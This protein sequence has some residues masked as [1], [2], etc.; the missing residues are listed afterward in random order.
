MRKVYQELL[1]FALEFADAAA[2]QIMPYYL[3]PNSSWA[4]RPAYPPGEAGSA[5]V[6][7]LNLVPLQ[8]YQKV[9]PLLSV[10]NQK[11]DL[12]YVFGSHETIFL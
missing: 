12:S 7:F 9:M 2:G 10:F 3:I 6:I 1:V 8:S 5:P 11:H 4:T